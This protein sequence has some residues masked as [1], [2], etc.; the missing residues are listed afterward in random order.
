MTSEVSPTGGGAPLAD[1]V[2]GGAA[3]TK[4]EAANL[5]A[6]LSASSL[7]KSEVKQTL[8]HLYPDSPTLG[9]GTFE[10][11]YDEDGVFT[12]ED[13]LK[14]RMEIEEKKHEIISGMLDAWIESIA[15][16][17]KLKKEER[18]SPAYRRWLEEQSASYRA[19]KE[20]EETVKT[21]THVRTAGNYEDFLRSLSLERR[22]SELREHA[23]DIV[24][25]YFD[26]VK[27]PAVQN[28]D[29]AKNA[30][31]GFLMETLV[32]MPIAM[33]LAV[34]MQDPRELSTQIE[35]KPISNRG[36]ALGA[37][38]HV[39]PEFQSQVLPAVN[40]FVMD[41]VK[42]ATITLYKKEQEQGQKPQDLEF[43]RAFGEK[44]LAKVRSEGYIK[45][46]LLQNIPG[47]EQMP[48]EAMEAAMMLMKLF[49]LANVVMLFVKI[50]GG[51]LQENELKEMLKEGKGIPDP[52]NKVAK[53]VIEELN[54]QIQ[55]IEDPQMRE[56]FVVTLL[57]YVD[58]RPDTEKLTSW[59]DA[60]S[61]ASEEV[62]S[63]DRSL[64]S[65]G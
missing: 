17:N 49:A 53:E 3:S 55:S 16:Q 35:V 24:S 7:S 42:N 15:E 40:F 36:D 21:K 6:L 47:A 12:K 1:G 62:S 28:S 39:P 27:D 20:D 5:W 64:R 33:G 30:L 54:R 46:E 11:L 51:N 41:M 63:I 65:G 2:A 43:A 60:L 45:G 58:S 14:F 8:V 57:K 61:A 25:N 23:R 52:D 10:T 18:L 37:F 56:E 22:A 19:K 4:S 44:V 59:M 13:Y 26:R 38:S 9:F 32:V 34:A 50:E 48:K 29:L 31:P